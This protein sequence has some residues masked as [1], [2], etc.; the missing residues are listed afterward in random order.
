LANLSQQLGRSLAW[1]IELGRI[2]NDDE[3]NRSLS[4]EYRAPWKHPTPENV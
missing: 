3:A 2:K 4:R 1:D